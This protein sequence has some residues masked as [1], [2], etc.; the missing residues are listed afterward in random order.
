[1]NQQTLIASKAARIVHAARGKHVSDFGTR[2]AHGPEAGQLVDPD[3][4]LL[5]LEAD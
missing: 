2:R 4:V 5:V 3:F 1:M